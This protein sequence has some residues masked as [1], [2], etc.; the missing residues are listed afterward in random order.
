MHADI[1]GDGGQWGHY[2]GKVSA[3]SS[4]TTLLI[5]DPKEP[6]NNYVYIHF[7]VPIRLSP[8]ARHYHI[9]SNSY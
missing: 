8:F 3:S 6:T 5:K 4:S 9:S 1:W 2:A 7:L